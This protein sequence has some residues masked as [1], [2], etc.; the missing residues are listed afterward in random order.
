M[1]YVAADVLFGGSQPPGVWG[2]CVSLFCFVLF[3]FFSRG[4]EKG[5]VGVLRGWRDGGRKGFSYNCVIASDGARGRGEGVGGTEDGLEVCRLEL[6]SFGR[7][8]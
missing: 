1:T 3:I 4:G 5:W 8:L 2:R 6:W 7:R